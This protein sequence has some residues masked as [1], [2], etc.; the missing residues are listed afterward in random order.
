MKQLPNWTKVEVALLIEAYQAIS[1]SPKAKEQ[2][3]GVLSTNL[4]NMA[5]NAGIEIDDTYRNLNGMFWQYGVIKAIF[6]GKSFGTRRPPVLFTELVDLFNNNK[7]EFLHILDEAHS[8]I[9]V[10]DKVDDLQETKSKKELFIIWMEKEHSNYSVS[11]YILNFEQVSNYAR[12]RNLSKSDFWDIDSYREFNKVRI[13]L[14]EAKIFKFTHRNLYRFFE[15]KGKLYS[16]FLRLCFETQIQEQQVSHSNLDA[17]ETVASTAAV[18]D[19]ANSSTTQEGLNLIVLAEISSVSL[20]FTRPVTYTFLDKKDVSVSSWIDVYIGVLNLAYNSYEYNFNFYLDHNDGVY[21]SRT[22]DSFRRAVELENGIFAEGNLN[23]MDLM[24]RLM[25]ILE[26]CN[27]SSSLVKIVYAKGNEGSDSTKGV[28][29]SKPSGGPVPTEII[30]KVESILKTHFANGI[31]T[32]KLI[33][34]IRF[35]QFYVNGTGSNIDD[36]ILMRCINSLGVSIGKKVYIIPDE[37][38]EKLMVIVEGILDDGFQ[39][40]YYERL[41]NLN[42]DWLS[43]YNIFDEGMLK[44]LLDTVKKKSARIAS[45]TFKQGYFST[46]KSTELLLIEEEIKRV[47]GDFPTAEVSTIANKLPYILF[48]KVRYSLA[49]SGDFKRNSEG[50]Y[51][52]KKFFNYTEE[53]ISAIRAEVRTRCESSGNANL[54]DIDLKSIFE[55]NYEMSSFAI[56]DFIYEF[57]KDEFD[58]KSNVLSLYGASDD[59]EVQIEKFCAGKHHCTL[60]EIGEVM[61]R[62]IGRVDLWRVIEYANRHMV[63]IDETN[64]VADTNVKFDIDVIDCVLDETVRGEFKGLK[65]IVTYIRFPECGYKWNA[66]LLESFIRR[67]SKDYKYMSL[68]SNSKNV[69]AIVKKNNQDDYHMILAKAVADAP[70]D[71]NDSDGIYNFLTEMGYLGRRSYKRIEELIM[72]IRKLRGEI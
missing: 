25:K 28:L 21:L 66:F 36:D 20:F 15:T 57:L 33:D 19:E 42:E 69:G 3:L 2:I 12:K 54:D 11:D 18:A 50:V 30:S 6:E 27:V 7:D 9:K 5:V 35:K 48:D 63:R 29:T 62:A 31:D 4:R 37:C 22:A 17:I 13:R 40:V 59:V 44:S 38:I 65:E 58:R 72:D 10:G 52:Y 53:Q 51:A 47:W 68:S 26:A 14:S 24:K 71:S 23:S 32:S 55:N 8:K 41:H 67:F 16:D 46:K 60:D 1:L 34:I 70:V 43:N 49:Y 61:R 39:I 45:L 56:Y 64:F